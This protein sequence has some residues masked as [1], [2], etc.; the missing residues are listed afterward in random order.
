[1]KRLEKV[2]KQDGK[3]AV[4]DLQV[5]TASDLPALGDALFNL[6]VAAGTI[7]QVIQTGKFYTLDDDGTWYDSD[8]NAAG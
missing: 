6:L 7:A 3:K 1:M 5:S 2:R 8:G 4:M